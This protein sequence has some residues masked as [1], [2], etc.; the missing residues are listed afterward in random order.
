MLN[1]STGEKNPTLVIANIITINKWDVDITAKYIFVSLAT[2][3][4]MLDVFIPWYIDEKSCVCTRTN[5]KT[6][7]SAVT[8]RWLNS[9]NRETRK[10]GRVVTKEEREGNLKDCNVFGSHSLVNT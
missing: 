4:I 5:T 8:V 9:R 3:S 1:S 7:T 6:V 2:V 10:S